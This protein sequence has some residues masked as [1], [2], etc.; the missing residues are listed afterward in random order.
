ML[1]LPP[2]AYEERERETKPFLEHLNDL[3]QM[4]VACIITLVITMSISFPL[5][6]RFLT[7]LKAPLTKVVPDPNKFL[8]TLN[9]TDAFVLA[10]QQIGRA[11][12]RERV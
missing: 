9:V 8:L 1:K 4:L 5:A 10:L 12:C 11:S 3:R 6:P 7:W 2:D